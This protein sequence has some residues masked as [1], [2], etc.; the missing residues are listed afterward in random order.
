M[1]EV[2]MFRGGAYKHSRLVELIEDLGGYILEKRKIAQEINLR[3]AVPFEDWEFIKEFADK[4]LD[5]SLKILP[6]L[7]CEVAVVSPTISR[8]HLPH[9]VCD[10]AEFFRRHGAY[11][12]VIG[13]STGRGKLRTGITED[14]IRIINE[15]ELAVIVLGNFRTCIEEK[16][17]IFDEIKIQKLFVGGPES[18]NVDVHYVGKIGRKGHRFNTMYEIQLLK[19]LIEKS[20]DLVK[21]L[22]KELELNQPYY[23]IFYIMDLIKRNVEDLEYTVAPTPMVPKLNGCRINLPFEHYHEKIENIEVEDYKLS[24]LAYI[25]KSYLNDSILVNLKPAH[26]VEAI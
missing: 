22:K 15:H 10:I 2:A 14:E 17:H 7:M 3:F 23:P 8:H 24:N 21:N 5:G 4:N 6:L 9:S 12:N 11:T 20:K 1:F 19:N 25:S 26:M 16:I 13:L 18:I